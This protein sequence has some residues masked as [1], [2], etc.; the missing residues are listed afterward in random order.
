MQDLT[1][2]FPSL[3]PNALCDLMAEMFSK[4]KAG[5]GA[6]SIRSEADP[7]ITKRLILKSSQGAD[8]VARKLIQ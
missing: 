5:Q 2:R 7:S 4:L 8:G 1:P 3:D 6:L